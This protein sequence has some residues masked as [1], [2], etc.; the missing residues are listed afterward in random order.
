MRFFRIPAF[1]GIEVHR[2]DADRGSLRVVEGCVPHGPGGLRSGPVWSK[3]GDVDLF[4]TGDQN[5][6]YAADDGQGNSVLTV[7]RESNVHDI[8][9]A[10]TENTA[11]VSLGASYD[12]ISSSHYED[13]PAHITPVGNRLYAIGDGSA[14]AVFTGKGPPEGEHSVYPDEAIYSQEWS[15]FPNC[16]FYVQGPK[17]TI[18]AA[19]NPA[20]PL[21]VYISEPAGMSQT[22]RDNPYSTAL[23]NHEEG[24]LSEVRILGSNSTKITAL[25]TR[26]DKVVVH[27]DKGCHILYAPTA[28]QAN[29]GYRTEQVA[30]TNTSAAVNNNVVAGNGGTQPFW[31]GHDGQVYKDEAAVRGAEDFKSYADPQQA[32]WKAKGKWEREHPNNLENSFATYDPQSGMYWVFIESSEQPLRVRPP[33]Y[34]PENLYACQPDHTGVCPSGCEELLNNVPSTPL[35]P[36]HISDAEFDPNEIAYWDGSVLEMS[37]NPASDYTFEVDGVLFHS[38]YTYEDS[39][40]GER[41]DFVRLINGDVRIEYYAS[42]NAGMKF[43]YVGGCGFN[44]AGEL[45]WSFTTGYFMAMRVDGSGICFMHGVEPGFS[46]PVNGPTNLTGSQPQAPASGPTNLTGSQAASQAPASGPTGLE[47]LQDFPI[48]VSNTPDGNDGTYEIER[49]IAGGAKAAWE[50]PN[51]RY[52]FYS[53]STQKWHYGSLGSTTTALDEDDGAQNPWLGNWTTITVTTGDC[54]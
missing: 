32:S 10:S 40:T 1:T 29:T 54:P 5:L 48:C 42:A 39:N 22:V 12:V 51:N 3:V 6:A 9:V 21:V 33:I 41:F 2:D 35:T 43:A 19:G 16:Q 52:I 11:L 45:E 26:G 13:V 28:D 47:A 15:R 31:L 20:D 23:T 46:P 30:A 49:Y 50:G 44:S 37:A 34:G 27:T 25:S 53:S 24:R 7:S 18:F 4:S 38:R 17:K 14:E 36:W 8:L